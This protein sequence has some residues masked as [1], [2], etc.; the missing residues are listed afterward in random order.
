MSVLQYPEKMDS[1]SLD[2]QIWNNAVYDN[3]GEVSEDMKGS[4]QSWGSLK[5]IFENPN[6]SFDSLSDKENNNINNPISSVSSSLKPSITPFK[7]VNA[8]GPTGRKSRI[9]GFSEKGCFDE[10]KSDSRKIDE[11]IEAIESEIS[12][13]KSRLESLRLEKSEMSVKAL[14]KRGRIVSAKFMDP[15]P[16]A[17]KVLRRGISLG[18]V[19]IMSSARRGAKSM[20]PSEIFG[21]TVKSRQQMSGKQESITTP[22]QN[23]RRKSCFWKLQD[24]DESPKRR[25]KSSSLSP[26]SRKAANLKSQ[27]TTRQAVTTIA[28][29]KT[30]SVI[31]NSVQPKKLFREGE[32]MGPTTSKKPLRPGRVVASRYNNQNPGPASAVMRKRSLP[33]NDDNGLGLKLDNNTGTLSIEKSRSK[34]R[35]EI[36]PSE[37]IVHGSDRL[38][39]LPRIKIAR[40]VKESPRDSGPAK[41]VAELIGRKSFFASDEVGPTVCQALD[42]AEA[43]DEE[44]DEE[45]SFP[46][47]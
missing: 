17:K 42:Y 39:L 34:K 28:S 15:T 31:N 2:L 30:L 20:G 13:L 24:I 7:P 37:I 23:N 33:E 47:Y 6:S 27:V 22:I 36:N 19:E 45:F 14:E 12:K 4:R 29:K 38:D 18:P 25:G 40:C 9:E 16:S 11:E 46:V 26:K 10:K 35:W 1:S 8:D 41:K 44:R 21:A 32:K 5:S 43:E 3:N